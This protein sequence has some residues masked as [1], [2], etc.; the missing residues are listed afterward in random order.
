MLLALP[1]IRGRCEHNLVFPAPDCPGRSSVTLYLISDCMLG[2]D[3]QY[4]IALNV[5]EEGEEEK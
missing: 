2:L 3:Q 1:Q 5:K 4:E